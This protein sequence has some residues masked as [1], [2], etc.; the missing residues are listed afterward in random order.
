MSWLVFGDPP[1]GGAQV[2]KVAAALGVLAL[3]VRGKL[4]FALPEPWLVLPDEGAARAK[5]EELRA[6]GASAVAAP[7]AELARIPVA[8]PVAEFSLEA[9]VFSWYAG[10]L[11]WKEIR[12]AVLYCDEPDADP[13]ARQ[14]EKD[15]LRD[16]ERQT[17]RAR[18]AAR[19]VGGIGGAALGSAMGPGGHERGQRG[20]PKEVL[21]LHGQGSRGPCRAR[22][23]K[24]DVSYQGLGDL[25][26]PVVIQNWLTLLEEIA[27]RGVEIDRRG[28]K[29]KVRKAL[30]GGV[31]LA[32]IF[33]ASP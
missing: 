14:K 32:K 31:G 9:S 23:V 22:I 7:A 27:R 28:Q 18:G 15:Q 30:V 19:M 16:R 12:S 33:E 21:E 25:R 13:H 11:P 3:E 5:V 8:E 4:S 29:T 6:A 2:P 24:G 10:D 20:E 17:Q 26:K 1:Q